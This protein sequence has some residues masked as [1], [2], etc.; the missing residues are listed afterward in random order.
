MKAL[1]SHAVI[2]AMLGWSLFT[3]PPAA[4]ATLDLS[5]YAEPSGPILILRGGDIV[6][7]YFVV[8]ALLLA[9]QNGLDITPYREKWIRWL[10]SRQKLDGTFDRYCRAG[11][12]WVG[13]KAADA[14]DAL[15]AMW[16]QLLESDP[17]ALASDVVLRTSYKKSADVLARLFDARRGIYLVSAIYQQGLFMDNLEVWAAQSSRRDA[18]SEGEAQRLAQA[19]HRVFWDAKG[20]RF[21]VS[22]Q[23]EQALA[24][25]H[26]Y[27]DSVAQIFPLLFGYPDLPASPRPYYKEWMKQHRKEWLAQI[28]HD[29]AWGLIALIALRQDDLPSARCWLREAMPF[30]HSEH[31]TVTDETVLQILQARHVQAAS[32]RA[33]CR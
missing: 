28:R 18:R 6:D 15:Q 4:A 22:T 29:F 32:P 14:D 24:A 16:M 13:C 10:V 27:P 2:V 19:I 30:R 9:Q 12:A 7:P 17:A 20:K 3:Q 11:P 31:W 33:S 26:F 5:G 23:P 8:Q 21:L 25:P 1:L